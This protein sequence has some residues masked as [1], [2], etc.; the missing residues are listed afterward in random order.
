MGD[1]SIDLRAMRRAV[2][3]AGYMGPIE[4]EIFNDRWRERPG[5]E[6]LDLIIKRFCRHVVD[7]APEEPTHRRDAAWAPPMT[8]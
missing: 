7:E 8:T 1:G 6:L 5:A 2:E 4:V 3:A